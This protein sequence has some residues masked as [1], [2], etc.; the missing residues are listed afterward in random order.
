VASDHRSLLSLALPGGGSRVPG[1]LTQL[2][3][4]SEDPGTKAIPEKNHGA[5]STVPWI[6]PPRPGFLHFPGRA[7]RIR[8]QFHYSS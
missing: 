3:R 4:V 2:E 7:G 1:H 6:L 8:V 5:V